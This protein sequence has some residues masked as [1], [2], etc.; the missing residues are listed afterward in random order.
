METE[1]VGLPK[2]ITCVELCKTIIIAI[3]VM[4]N[5]AVHVVGTRNLYKK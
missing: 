2:N 3:K 4:F 5:Y 1:A